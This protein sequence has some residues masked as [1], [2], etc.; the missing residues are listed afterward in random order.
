MV[1]EICGL[2]LCVKGSPP[3]WQSAGDYEEEVTV[4]MTSDGLPFALP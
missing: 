2:P 4:H 3:I 1:S